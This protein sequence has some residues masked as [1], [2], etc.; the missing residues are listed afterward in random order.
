MNFETSE[1]NTMAYQQEYQFDHPQ[2]LIDLIVKGQLT[3]MLSWLTSEI[4]TKL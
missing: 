1:F 4:Q 3:K 2:K